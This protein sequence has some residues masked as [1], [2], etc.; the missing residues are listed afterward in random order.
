MPINFFKKKKSEEK[1]SRENPPA[2]E[3]KLQE[4]PQS[5][6]LDV[7]PVKKQGHNTHINPQ[8]T[9]IYD[10]KKKEREVRRKK[11]RFVLITILLTL[12]LLL[13]IFSPAGT[14]FYKRYFVRPGPIV[15]EPD[16][17]DEEPKKD[18]INPESIVEYSNDELKISLEHLRKASLFE[19]V[20]NTSLTKRIEI[21][22]DRN[23]ENDDTRLENLSE[24]YIFRISSF[25]TSFRS[26]DEITQVKKDAFVAMCPETATLTK[27]VGVN[28]NGVD[29]RTFEVLNCE[30]DYK[31]SYV[32]KNG[33]N[34]EFAQIFKG[35]IGYKQLYKAETE[36]ILRSVEFYPDEPI[37]LGPTETYDSKNYRLSFVYPRTL[38]AE[39]CSITGP[40]SSTAN[41]LLT[42]G[43]TENR[44][45]EDNYDIIGFFA[46]RNTVGDFNAYIEKQKSLLTD[47]YLVTMGQQPLNPQI[48]S[49]KVG[50]R[51]GIMLR[52]YSWRENDLIYV[53]ITPTG[54]KN[55]VLVISIKN[56]TGEGFEDI[57]DSILDS[58]EFY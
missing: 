13:I 38:D 32:V 39:C 27:T 4:N 35:D 2:Q 12:S 20:E 42:L 3:Q 58:F 40:I 36:N 9:P 55:L 50:D 19:N 34:Y 56:I 25:T 53:D 57:T 54:K 37:E 49:V 22:Y 44:V 47:D 48:R 18:K 24:G 45:N 52:G 51:E 23:K 7:T 30:A 11:R 17:K 16:D 33:L 5:A 10:I 43:E 46:D 15:I 26:I 6:S 1:D 31:V 28:I 21:V 29:G 41:I 14:S 8:P